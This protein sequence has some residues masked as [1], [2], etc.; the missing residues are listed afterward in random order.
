MPRSALLRH[1]VAAV[2]AATLLAGIGPL[3]STAAAAPV[4][5]TPAGAAASLDP[6]AASAALTDG[7]AIQYV[8]D[9]RTAKNGAVVT[10]WN[11]IP[12]DH[13]KRELVVSVRPAGSG[14]WGAPHVLTTTAYERGNAELVVSADGSVTAA[15]VE[16]PNDILNYQEKP[17]AV[18]RM[19]VLAAGAT[20]WS[21]PVD[22]VTD[23]DNIQGGKL[24]GSPSGTL[25]AVWRRNSERS[26]ALYSSVREAPGQAWSEPARL[27]EELADMEIV[28][29][30]ELV[31]SDQGTATVAF[32][33]YGA[34]S[35][36][37]KVADRAH[38]GTGWTKP[39]TVSDPNADTSNPTLT[40][41]QDGRSTL[42]WTTLESPE[43]GGTTEVFAQ[44]PAGSL[45][46]GA[47]EPINGFATGGWRK[48]A[49]GPEGDV[50]V[51]GVAYAE[52]SGF[53]A[54]TATRSAATGNWS[55]VKTLSTGSATEDQ[56]D[57]AVGSDGSAH[58]VWSQSG[59][60][61]KT[62][63]S[64]RVNGVWSAAPTALSTNTSG[65]AIGQITVGADNR[66]VAVWAQS[67]GDFTTQV[68]AA[69]TAPVKP[70][71]KWRDFSGDGKG[72]LLAL[73]SGGT[74]TVRTGSGAG[75]LGTGASATGWPA[76]SMVVP[77]GDLS[78]DR[79][80]D[81]LV[82]NSAGVL[83]RYDG[84][85]G[86]A[87]SPSG[88]RLTIGSGWNIYNALTSPGDLTGD[89]RTDLVARTPAGELWLYA[90]NGAG[91]LAP[92]V[93]IGNGWQIYNTVIGVGDLNGDKFGDLLARDTAGVLWRYNGTGK[94]TFATRVKV[95][96]GWQIYNTLATVGDITADGKAD[97]VARDTAGVLW[98]YN[99]TGAGTFAGRVR[100]G[101]GWQM[102]KTLS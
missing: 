60:S 73:T 11:R 20:T 87:F 14:T 85:C 38:D 88:T 33:Q 79:C 6:W 78:G 28:S 4:L 53:R 47:Q 89:G 32:T 46:W 58:A 82:R 72:D 22:I 25:V 43:G 42:V 24:V 16:Y 95:G 67:T 83:T 18:F 96:G 45:V 13:S 49:V 54:L 19:A 41:G 12:G 62:M 98:R 91:K 7:T 17:G 21:T 27:D 97:L 5:S 23:P 101:G 59:S 93:K 15:W 52:G 81:L 68:R 26:S 10:L 55:A 61:R 8:L 2:A 70:L 74:L 35:Y 77:I 64:S 66:P 44:R 71:P 75:G 90:D 84:S 29:D 48:V 30:P 50:T 100:I 9:V 99:G 1:S 34:G 40:L 51:L 31:Y 36:A 56:F 92:R 3:S 63:T 39:V 80:N 102:Y 57:L 37:I 65:Y 94:G 76:T 69:T 86:K